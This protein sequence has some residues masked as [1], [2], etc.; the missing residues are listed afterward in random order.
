MAPKFIVE[1]AQ[2]GTLI[3]PIIAVI[4][5]LL[6]ITFGLYALSG[7]GILRRLP[8]LKFDI[9]SI[10]WV[11]IVRGILPLQLWLRHPEAVN[12]HGFITARNYAY[13]NGEYVDVYLMARVI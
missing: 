4:V 7:A 2:N 3:A 10:A 13:R 12:K 6:F 8:L 5:S 11:S 1:S 9:Y